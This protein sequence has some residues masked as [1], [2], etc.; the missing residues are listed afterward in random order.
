MLAE[1]HG[2]ASFP[3][4]AMNRI[5]LTNTGLLAHRYPNTT[6]QRGSLEVVI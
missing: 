4:L 3:T 5:A 2:R 1:P 6:P